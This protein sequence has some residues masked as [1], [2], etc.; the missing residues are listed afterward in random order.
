MPTVIILE[1]YG[2]L[3]PGEREI[4]GR[5]GARFDLL[6]VRQA[7]AKFKALILERSYSRY[8]QLGRH[9]YRTKIFPLLSFCFLSLLTR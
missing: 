5:V 4:S 6:L 8:L 3:R 7:N 2:V 9:D 1:N